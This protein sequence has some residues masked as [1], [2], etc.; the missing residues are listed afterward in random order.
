[1]GCSLVDPVF[2]SRQEQEI[3]LLQN[4]QTGFGT[5]LASY[6]VNTGGF[7]S[8]VKAAEAAMDLHIM[9]RF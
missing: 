2:K 1:V 9:P 4:D 8:L 7:F 3:S 5:H 6:L